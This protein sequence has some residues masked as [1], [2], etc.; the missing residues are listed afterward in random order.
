MITTLEQN[1]EKSQTLSTKK[2][3]K[4]MARGGVV[5]M[6]EGGA[7]TEDKQ[8]TIGGTTVQKAIYNPNNDR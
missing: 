4:Q 2:S 5:K 8:Q 3:A 1:P 7:V 6:Q